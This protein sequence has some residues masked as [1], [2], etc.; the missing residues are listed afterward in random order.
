LYYDIVQKTS[1]VGIDSESPDLER[2]LD[3]KV[4][5]REDEVGSREARE[6]DPVPHK[7]QICHERNV[8]PQ[9]FNAHLCNSSDTKDCAR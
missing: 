5:Y 2:K 7:F 6:S 8:I 1:G 9:L 4:N 3:D